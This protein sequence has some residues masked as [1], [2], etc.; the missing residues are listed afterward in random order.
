MKKYDI[1]YILFPIMILGLIT[2]NMLNH[3]TI[4]LSNLKSL[5]VLSLQFH[6]F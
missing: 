1:I 6:F 4:F 2:L 3:D 5:L